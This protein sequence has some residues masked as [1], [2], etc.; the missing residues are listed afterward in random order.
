MRAAKRRL[1]KASRCAWVWPESCTVKPSGGGTSSST[2][3]TA[4]L[5]VPRST[6]GAVLAVTSTTRWRYFRFTWTGPAERFT[7]RHV[8]ER[9]HRT[10]GGLDEHVLQVGH[11]VRA[12]RR[13]AAR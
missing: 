13:R 3:S 11:L 1:P 6:P 2:F 4:A 10:V 9:E 12:R 8:G 7:W 5:A